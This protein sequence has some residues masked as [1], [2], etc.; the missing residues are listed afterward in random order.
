[1]NKVIKNI[2][3]ILLIGFATTIIRIIGQ[4]SIPA[5]EQTVL[6]PSIFAQNGTMPLVFTVYGIFAY[7]LI[8][9]LFLLI[10]D[11]MVGNRILQGLKYGLVC[12]AVW[13]VYLLEPLP[14]VAALDRITYPIAD[15]V[16]LIIMGLMLGWLF[17]KSK[18]S[19]DWQK[20]AFPVLPVL[21]VTVC[22][23]AGR[24][25]Q[26]LIFDT[27]SS[28]DEKTLETVL[29]CLL[30]GIAISCVMVW[31]N[32]HISNGNRIKR[33]MILGCLL[34]GVDL[35]LFNF[36][37]PLVFSADI[38]D[39]ILRTFVDILTVTLGCLV[40][41]DTRDLDKS[42]GNLFTYGQVS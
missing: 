7:S 40:F 4:L 24:M 17:G 22:F 10:R 28:F 14:H 41:S 13:I 8:A 25:I 16:A 36:F 35:I 20:T 21:T 38:P 29:W 33:A 5:G 3:K 39:L 27:Y 37:M 31:L 1:M 12:C 26:Y 9:A 15:S 6:A 19:A 2:L 32:L 11:R 23:F 30:T 18:R 42:P 34:F